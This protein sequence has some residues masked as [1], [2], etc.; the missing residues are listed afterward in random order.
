MANRFDLGADPTYG[1]HLLSREQEFV[2][3]AETLRL[4]VVSRP[5]TAISLALPM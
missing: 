1:S 4:Q 3:F 2:K 5:T